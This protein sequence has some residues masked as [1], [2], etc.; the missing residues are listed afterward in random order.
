MFVPTKC[1]PLPADCIEPSLPIINVAVQHKHVGKKYPRNCI[2]TVRVCLI[3][4]AFFLL[5]RI[6]RGATHSRILKYPNL[7]KHVLAQHWQE[8]IPNKHEHTHGFRFH[9]D[10]FFIIKLTEDWLNAKVPGKHQSWIWHQK[11][12]WKKLSFSVWTLQFTFLSPPE[13]LLPLEPTFVL[14]MSLV[15]LIPQSAHVDSQ[16]VCVQEQLQPCKCKV[17]MCLGH[18]GMPTFAGT[19]KL[20]L[21]SHDQPLPNPANCVQPLS[22]LLKV[23]SLEAAVRNTLTYWK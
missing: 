7:F 23:W 10:G 22:G 19:E 5:V 3:F 12:L 4:F 13:L 11:I 21:C 20:K 6:Y 18:D 14:M 1:L 17:L 15:H 16:R 8:W 2:N 9:L